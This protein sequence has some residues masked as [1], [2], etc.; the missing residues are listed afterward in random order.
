M[1]KKCVYDLMEL[2]AGVVLKTSENTGDESILKWSGDYPIPEIGR[3]VKINF[4]ELGTGSVQSYFTE[5]GYLGIEVRLDKEPKWKKVQHKGTPREGI[6]LVFGA[7][8][9]VL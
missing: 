6:A 3:K 2:P 1:A 9:T 8:I 4:N 5:Y 7:E